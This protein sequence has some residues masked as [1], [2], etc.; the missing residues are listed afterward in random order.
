MER[1]KLILILLLFISAILLE[2][3]KIK[4][5]K[6]SVLTASNDPLISYTKSESYKPEV[7][8]CSLN[9]LNSKP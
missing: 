2:C 8:N 1:L 4:T 3:E 5:N 9:S 7:R 6:L